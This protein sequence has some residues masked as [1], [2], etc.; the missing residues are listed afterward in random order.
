MRASGEKNRKKEREEHK[1]LIKEQDNSNSEGKPVDN[2]SRYVLD[3]S[4]I[5]SGF[6]EVKG[7]TVPDV[8]LEVKDYSSEFTLESLLASDKL[9]VQEPSKKAMK[10]VR[11]AVDKTKDRLSDTDVKVIAL[12]MDLDAIVVSGDYGIQNVCEVLDV[13]YLSSGV[14]GINE[15]FQWKF[16]CIGCGAEYESYLEECSFCGNPVVRRRKK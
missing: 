9:D 12:A 10:A 7:Y 13:P 15:V 2:S 11:R 3:A 8:I 4:A 14:E 5:I 6:V 16:V 1:T